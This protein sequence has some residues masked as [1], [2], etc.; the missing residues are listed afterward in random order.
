[1]NLRKPQRGTGGVAGSELMDLLSRL[2][3]REVDILEVS[4]SDIAGRI[5]DQAAIQLGHD[6][7]IDSLSE[8]LVTLSELMQLKVRK[9]LPPDAPTAP[10]DVSSIVLPQNCP[11]EGTG[12]Y[13]DVDG[14]DGDH[15]EELL[16]RLMQY[17]VFKDAAA[18]LERREEIWRNVYTRAG[19]AG[20]GPAGS[21]GMHPRAYPQ[22]PDAGKGD[23]VL[24][25][26]VLLQLLDELR[27]VLD[28]DPEE[29]L[30]HIPFEDMSIEDKM[31]EVM[32]QVEKKGVTTFR[33]LF[34]PY[35]TRLEIIAT[36]LAI[37]ELIRLM[38]L[39]VSQEERFGK[40][41]ISKA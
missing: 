21:E 13:V 29:A 5:L 15:S 2:E 36:F 32:A 25:K 8:L 14:E 23:G 6:I 33:D 4:I 40:I 16:D 7:D 17:R 28:A 18:E 11:E 41:I 20:P 10:G 30:R 3:A 22:A 19:L 39:N 9:L 26:D 27:E 1:M 38:K 24:S 37:L 31:E 35:S 34:S 12:T